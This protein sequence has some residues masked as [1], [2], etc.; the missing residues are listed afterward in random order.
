MVF[1]N[2]VILPDHSSLTITKGCDS[3]QKNSRKEKDHQKL[4]DCS[5]L[6][7]IASMVLENAR[8]ASEAAHQ[9]FFFNYK[10]FQDRLL[11]IRQIMKF[12]SLFDAALLPL[13]VVNIFKQAH[14]FVQGSRNAKIDS[15]IQLIA[16]TGLLTRCATIIAMGVANISN[17]SMK[18][19][20]WTSSLFVATS[21]LSV[22]ATAATYRTYVKMRKF[23]KKFANVAL[24]KDSNNETSLE[25]FQASLRFIKHKELKDKEFIIKAFNCTLEKLEQHLQKIEKEA[26]N[27]IASSNEE[28]QKAG[29]QLLNSTLKTLKE[30]IHYVG[31][32]SR[33]NVVIST[34]SL[35]AAIALFASPGAVIATYFV[36]GATLVANLGVLIHHKIVQYRY[37]QNLGMHKKWYEWITC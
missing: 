13:V 31:N 26:A 24:L 12:T 7:Y 4:T 20:N 19:L 2:S 37:T 22:A 14:R 34:V 3:K 10:I 9:T 15:A 5:K 36:G 23:E 8:K 35:V 16:D 29:R 30:H 11:Q 32:A 18:V 33:M 25:A 17:V 27:K 28:E 21:I 1:V 6:G